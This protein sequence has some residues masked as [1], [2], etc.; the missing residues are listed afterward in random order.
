M[1]IYLIFLFIYSFI[2]RYIYFREFGFFGHVY[3]N[4]FKSIIRMIFFGLKINCIT[5]LINAR[6]EVMLR[7]F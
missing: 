6:K 2:V 3:T 7:I 1:F 5:K 4:G